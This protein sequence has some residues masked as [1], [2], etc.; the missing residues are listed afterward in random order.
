VEDIGLAGPARLARCARRVRN[1]R[2]PRQ[3]GGELAL[4]ERRSISRRGRIERVFV[5]YNR[6]NDFVKEDE[7]RPRAGAPA[8]C[9]DEAH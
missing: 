6:A 1:L 8:Q 3:P 9:A 7:S 2:A 4:A 5:A